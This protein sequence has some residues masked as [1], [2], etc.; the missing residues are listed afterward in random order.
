MKKTD[1]LIVKLRDKIEI[2]NYI[3]VVRVEI[4]D[5]FLIIGYICNSMIRSEPIDLSYIDYWELKP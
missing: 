3:N 1:K 4:I 5:G 2:L